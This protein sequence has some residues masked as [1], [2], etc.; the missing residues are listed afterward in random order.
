MRG[1]VTVVLACVAALVFAATAMAGGYP[2]PSGGYDP[3]GGGGTGGDAKVKLKLTAKKKQKSLKKVKVAASCE[4]RAC[5][6]KVGGKLKAGK[7]KS[8][9][10]G[11]EAAL[12]TGESQAFALKFSK[13]GRK[14]AKRAASDDKKLTAKVSATAT[15]VGGGGRDQADLKIKLKH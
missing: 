4:V 15:G 5:T 8:K 7:K 2:D 10:K 6:V 11:D 13:K 1:K 3:S 14:A 12:T 9:L